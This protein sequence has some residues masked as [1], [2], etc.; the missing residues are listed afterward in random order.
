V[1]QITYNP[2]IVDPEQ[3]AIIQTRV[4]NYFGCNEDVLQNK[5]VG[6]AW[7]AYYEGKI[8]PFA[9]Q[10]SQAMTCMTYTKNELT[11]GNAIVWTANRLQYMTNVDKLQVSSQMFD[12]GILSTNDVMD[13]WNLP[14][15]ADGDKRYIR[16][17]Y[18]E[19]SQLDQ[20]S[21]LQAELTAAQ[22]ALNAA[23]TPKEP[24]EGDENNDSDR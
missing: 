2:Q 16:K 12:R 4:L 15:V 7:S 22:N 11:R 3:M 5:T 9:I 23:K 24:N 14:H 6:D 10:L 21:Q 20:V 1:Q 8:E 13:I 19:V 17:E 18:T